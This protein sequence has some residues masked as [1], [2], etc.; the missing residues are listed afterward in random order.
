MILSEEHIAQ[1][2]P[3]NVGPGTI[4]GL[5]QISPGNTACLKNDHLPR[6]WSSNLTSPY[7]RSVKSLNYSIRSNFK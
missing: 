1:W 2:W 7:Y 4:S 6:G 5:D 3:R